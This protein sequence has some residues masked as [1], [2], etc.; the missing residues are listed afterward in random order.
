M[1]TKQDI[2]TLRVVIGEEFDKRFDEKFDKKFDKKF[3]EKFNEKFDEK[4]EIV[5]QQL[6]NDIATFKDE[7]ISVIY[8]LKEDHDLLVGRVSI[9]RDEAE[10]MDRRM[11]TVEK[12]LRIAM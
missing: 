1:L 10:E 9:M 7:I 11:V 12:R 2:N 5:H 8:P 6:R 3:D 4:F